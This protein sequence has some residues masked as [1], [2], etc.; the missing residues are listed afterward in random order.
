MN[1]SYGVRLWV[2]P[3]L[4]AVASLAA[5]Q[6]TTPT[7]APTPTVPP[8]LAHVSHVD[9]TATLDREAQ[10]EP[11]TAGIPLLPGDR[12][13][14]EA[15]RVEVLFA[16]GSALHLDE[17]TTADVLATDL[18]RLLDGRVFLLAAG[19]RDPARAQRYQVDAPAASA[20]TNWP[21]QYRMAAVAGRVELAV[22][23]GEATLATEA[24]AVTLR[25]GEHAY[26]SEGAAPSAPEYF[27]SARWDTFDRWSA[28]RRGEWTGATSREYLPGELSAY[29]GT[30]DQYGTWREEPSVGYVWYPTVQE[31]WRPYYNG[32][33]RPYESWGSVWIGLDPWG[34]ATHHYGRWGF[35]SWGWY[36]IPSRAWGPGWVSWSTAPGYVSWCALGYHDGPV[37][38][39]WGLR[40]S[41]YGGR[42]D[43]WRGWTVVP[44][45]AYG[46]RIAVHRAAVDGRRLDAR[47]RGSFVNHR[48]PPTPD[49]AAS[50]S[51][52]ANG[53]PGS[54]T[55]RPGSLAAG[56]PAQGQRI[57]TAVPRYGRNDG[58][59]LTR[60]ADAGAG[61]PS[62]GARRSVPGSPA[63]GSGGS[64]PS[65]G[66]AG[67]AAGRRYQTG[68]SSESPREYTPLR[69]GSPGASGLPRGGETARPR[70]G[71]PQGTPR[72]GDTNDAP[73]SSAPRSYSSP[74]ASGLPRGGETAR[75][76]AGFPPGAP[77]EGDTNDAPRTSAPRT[78]SS[79]GASGLPR[80]GETA[81]PRAGV[82]QG[83]PRGGDTNDAPRT[84]APRSYSSP[85]ASGLPRGESRPSP[86]TSAPPRSYEQSRSYDAPRSSPSPRSAPRTS[87]SPRSFS[88]RGNGSGSNSSG[89]RYNPGTS[90]SRGSARS[91][92]PSRRR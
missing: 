50:R 62:R 44:R 88:P 49:V 84:S 29:A 79:P 63:A 55:A 92:A 25:A 89:P 31:D 21:G 52:A 41:V 68:A 91:S 71:F 87:E 75:P 43:P 26:A 24:G 27:N 83:A 57:G 42:I 13:R 14:T 16:D 15:G 35:S 3:C 36:W 69:S 54:G 59:G 2:L 12:L 53:R 37:F 76:R 9:G 51:W 64:Q 85:G 33:W 60:P 4:L 80:G 77:R 72:G 23:T 67:P 45:H 30:L 56:R 81:R 74:G 58:T 32:Y 73:P 78:Y 61:G 19:G 38:G 7:P 20:Q 22:I 10:T 8:P 11:L 82:P 28:S 6:T 34:W 39:L 86:R 65:F 90:S 66:T 70:A 48:R 46:G 40:G 18:V 17:S 5:A 1:L 47:V